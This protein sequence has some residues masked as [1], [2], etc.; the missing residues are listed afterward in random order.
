MHSQNVQ[1]V[2]HVVAMT[3]HAATDAAWGVVGQLVGFV[4]EHVIAALMHQHDVHE[5][6]E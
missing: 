6:R 2:L 5:T 4:I 3:E 1:G